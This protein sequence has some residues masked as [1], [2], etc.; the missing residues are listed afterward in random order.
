MI[1]TYDRGEPADSYRLNRL[2][3]RNNWLKFRTAGKLLIILEDFIEY[4]PRL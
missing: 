2:S 1:T 4:T 3:L